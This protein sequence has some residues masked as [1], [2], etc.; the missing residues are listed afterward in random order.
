MSNNNKTILILI[1]GTHHDIHVTEPFQVIASEEK[2]CK[3]LDDLHQR[4]SNLAQVFK[5]SFREKIKHNS[6]LATDV[7]EW[8]IEYME[9]EHGSVESNLDDIFEKIR[10]YYDFIDCK[11][12]LDMSNE[13][14]QDVTFSDGGVTYKLVDELHSHTLMSESLCKSNPVSALKKLLQEH[15]KP[16]DKN[17]DNL[18]CINICLGT[19]WDDIDIKGLFKLIKKLLPQDYGQSLI[20]HITITSSKGYRSKGI[21]ISFI[22][23]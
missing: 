5:M 18:P 15:Y 7:S 17:M 1:G 6:Q 14:L 16:F 22:M 11:L 20:E 3:S 10:P 2:V 13:F 19:Y 23:Y 12:L 21:N 4:F 8:L 9:W